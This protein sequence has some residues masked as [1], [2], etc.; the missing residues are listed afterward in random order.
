MAQVPL[1]SPLAALHHETKISI[2]FFVIIFLGHIPLLPWVFLIEKRHRE[3]GFSCCF[4]E[5]QLM[6]QVACYTYESKSAYLR[7]CMH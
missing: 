1:A 6:L 4:F 5:H 3:K 2:L 7:F